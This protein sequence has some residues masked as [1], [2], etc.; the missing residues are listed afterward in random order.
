MHQVLQLTHSSNKFSNHQRKLIY[1]KPNIHSC[2]IFCCCWEEEE[3]N[4]SCPF[5]ERWSQFYP[6]LSLSV[7]NCGTSFTSTQNLFT[8]EPHN[9]PTPAGPPTIL[10]FCKTHCSSKTSC[11]EHRTGSSLMSYATGSGA[12]HGSVYVYV[13]VCVCVCVCGWVCV[14]VCV[15]G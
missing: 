11:Q 5:P 7:F 9:N 6:H 2:L 13:C 14:C 1:A 3:K 8:T 12:S 10:F 15:C 4:A